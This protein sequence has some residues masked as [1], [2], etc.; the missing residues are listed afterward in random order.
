MSIFIVIFFYYKC[1]CVLFLWKVLFSF[2]CL[3]RFVILWRVFS[4]LDLEVFLIN[5]FIYFLEIL[6]GELVVW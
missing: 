4:W 2:W 3:I 5:Y 1:F 6:K